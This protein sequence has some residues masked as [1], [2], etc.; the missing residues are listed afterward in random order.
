[1]S[2]P[3]AA[4][5]HY[6]RRTKRATEEIRERTSEFASPIA[7]F[8]MSLP[9]SQREVE[10]LGDRLLRAGTSV[11]VYA[12]EASRSRSDAEMCSRLEGAIQRADESMLCLEMLQENGAIK[13]GSPVDCKRHAKGRIDIVLIF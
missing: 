2:H 3:I 1:M 13:P 11:A 8:R 12:R 7:R 6:E 10:M 4:S 9:N 5:S